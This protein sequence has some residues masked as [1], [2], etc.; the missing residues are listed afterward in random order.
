MNPS[1]LKLLLILGL[2]SI[3]GTFLSWIAKFYRKKFGRGPSS[4]SMHFFLAVLVAGALLNLKFFNL[5]PPMLPSVV[6]SVGA[7]G[8]GVQG[9]RLYRTL[10][11]PG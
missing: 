3:S 1:D 5:I 4:L 9:I 7:I 10:M 8:F 2:F 6:I 11:S